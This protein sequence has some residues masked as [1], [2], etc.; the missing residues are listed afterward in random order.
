MKLPHL[1]LV[2]TG[3]RNLTPAQWARAIAGLPDDI[4]NHGDPPEAIIAHLWH[5]GAHGWD[6]AAGEWASAHGVPQ[7]CVPYEAGRPAEGKPEVPRAQWG[8]RRN[9]LMMTR[10]RAMAREKGLGIVCLAGWNGMSG[11]T[12]HG[13]AVATALRIDVHVY[14]TWKEGR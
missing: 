5:G 8:K 3:G 9:W 6:R 13:M 10:A 14:E 11:G 12:A 4:D 1:V 2:V 7:T